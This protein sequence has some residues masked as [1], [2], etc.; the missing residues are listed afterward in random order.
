MDEKS[1]EKRVSRPRKSGFIPAGRAVLAIGLATGGGVAA[2]HP[3]ESARA[4]VEIV[5]NPQQA[6]V[7][8]VNRLSNISELPQG[9]VEIAPIEQILSEEEIIDLF[10]PHLEG[11]D[12]ETL[13]IQINVV[14]A[15][16]RDRLT[17]ESY[18]NID[19]RMG[20]IKKISEYT[21]IPG[22]DFVL[23]LGAESLGGKLG[24]LEF[25]TDAGALGDYQITEAVGRE[26]GMNITNDQNDDRLDHD[27][28]AAVVA[29]YLNRS[30]KIFGDNEGFVVWSW[31]KGPK[32]VQGVLDQY[33]ALHGDVIG[34]YREYIKEKGLNVFQVLD[35]AEI[36]KDLEDPSNNQNK[37][38]LFNIRGIASAILYFHPE[39][40]VAPK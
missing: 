18:D 22:E 25:M 21:H 11:K 31:H 20:T 40:R 29:A 36:N 12:R 7:D 26:F 23:L 9:K 24:G 34:D 16:M 14:K 39:Q 1:G 10:Y 37:T 6:Y 38:T 27:K 4:V 5:D 13:K 19:K 32:G 2:A 15:D 33:A 35:Q 17:Q 28:S 30:A 8:L 3:A